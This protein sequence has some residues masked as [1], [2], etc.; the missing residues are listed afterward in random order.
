MEQREDGSG[1][2]VNIS[3]HNQKITGIRITFDFL[4]RLLGFD[5]IHSKLEF[6]KMGPRNPGFVDTAPYLCDSDV[7]SPVTKLMNLVSFLVAVIKSSDKSSLMEKELI[8]TLSSRY[9]PRG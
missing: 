6:P 4:K 9:G 8:F 3:N 1:C 2:D 5:P 7:P